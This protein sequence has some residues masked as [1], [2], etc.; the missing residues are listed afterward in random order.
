MYNLYTVP[1]DV[2]TLWLA[3][4]SRPPWCFVVAASL[5]VAGHNHIL[6][7][8]AD[9]PGVADYSP[10]VAGSPGVADYSPGVAGSQVAGH[11]P[12]VGRIQR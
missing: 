1:C 4:L 11:M 3:V 12:E 7:E 2:P 10:V 6:P 9:S 5:V 8:V